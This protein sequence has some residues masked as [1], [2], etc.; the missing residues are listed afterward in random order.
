MSTIAMAADFTEAGWNVSRKSNRRNKRSQDRDIAK[1]SST[2]E[3][4]F[5]TFTESVKVDEVPKNISWAELDD[6]EELDNTPKSVW[7]KPSGV[8]DVVVDTKSY[9]TLDHSKVIR[10][11]RSKFVPS[12]NRSQV[13]EVETQKKVVNNFRCKCEDC[14][15][16][17][18]LHNSDFEKF[19]EEHG[20]YKLV[21]LVYGKCLHCRL[22]AVKDK[23]PTQCADIKCSKF[24]WIKP[25][26]L[27]YQRPADKWEKESKIIRAELCP[28]CWRQ[29]RKF[30]DGKLEPMKEPWALSACRSLVKN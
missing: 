24:F 8:Q 14:G 26:H 29:S 25:D 15:V 22:F 10:N 28:C 16:K 9:P 4:R 3:I 19:Q 11:G 17:Y 27:Y 2:V 20:K 7:N 23:V 21:P 30:M 18:K 13:F 12:N 1:P 5:G 6:M